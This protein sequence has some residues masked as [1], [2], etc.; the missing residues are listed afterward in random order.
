MT[1]TLTVRP[2]SL[3]PQPV[4]PAIRIRPVPRLEPPPDDNGPDVGYAQPE[5]APTL[6]IQFGPTAVGVNRSARMRSLAARDGRSEAAAPGPGR[7]SVAPLVARRFVSTCLEVIGGYRPT[8]HLR[9]LCSPD[10]FDRVVRLLTGRGMAAEPSRTLGATRVPAGSPVPGRLT[11]RSPVT[12]RSRTGAPPRNGRANQK[13]PGDRIDI[14]KIHVGEPLEG[15]A[16][17][18]VVLTRQERVWAMALRLEDRQGRW[19]CTALEVL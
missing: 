13:S 16:E 17:V 9:P 7:P 6:P 14:R 2:A 10:Q 1:A 4:L 11:A 8:T 3:A 12:G 5:S 15:V 19:I 18:A